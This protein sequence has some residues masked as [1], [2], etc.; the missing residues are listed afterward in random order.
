MCE[1]CRKWVDK[2]HKCYMESR[3]ALGGT[4]KKNCVKNVEDQSKWCEECKYSGYTEKYMFFDVETNQETGNHEVNLV[5]NHDF[6]GNETIFDNVNDY[7]E[8][9]FDEEHVNYTIL[10]HYGK[11]FDFQFLSK[12]CFKNKIKVFTIYQGNKLIY[13]KANDYNIRFIDSINFTLLPLRKFPKTFGLKE[14]TK[15][16][17]PHLFNTSHNQKYIG[18]Y[19]EK[20]YYGYDSMT[21]DEKKLFDKWYNTVKNETY[22]FQKEFI[23]YCRSDVNILRRGC[24]EFRRLFLEIA[25]IDPFKYVTLAGVCMAIFRDKFLQTNTIAIDEEII[26]KDQ[27]SKKSIASLD[28][29][30]KKHTVNIQHALNGRE[31]KLKLGN[32]TYKVDAFYN[33][34][35]YQFQ[36]C[37]WH[38]YPRCY[39][40]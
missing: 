24:L 5:I 8:W 40:E 14:L 19:P 3:K 25:N 30:S 12:Y 11:G 32:K 22:D 23:K 18:K 33:N 39:R 35:V 34:T 15:G 38:G 21:D 2:D 7:C 13:M 36:G 29:L 1:N 17:F 37:H 16:Y 27:Y 4:C 10:A 26:Q 28:Y 20:Y 9:L 6:E 31:K